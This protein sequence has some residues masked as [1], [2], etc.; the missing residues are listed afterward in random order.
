MAILLL[1]AP[2]KWIQIITSNHFFF[3]KKR[4]LQKLN[5]S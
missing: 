4:N 2:E 3:L 5:K 1:D